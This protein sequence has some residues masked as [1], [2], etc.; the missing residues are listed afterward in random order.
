[1]SFA[2]LLDVSRS[3]TL[4]HTG[5]RFG[6]SW[7]SPLRSGDRVIVGSIA[8]PNRLGTVFTDNR[9][10]MQKEVDAAFRR[11]MEERS[12]PSPIWDAIAAAVVGLETQR[13]FRQ[14]VIAVTDG[15]S[16]GN[17]RGFNDMLMGATAAGVSVSIVYAPTGVDSDPLPQTGGGEVRILAEPGLL[18][19]V[20]ETGGL[21]RHAGDGPYAN[22]EPHVEKITRWLHEGYVLGFSAPVP[23]GKWHKLDVKVKR[24]GLVV[25]ARKAFVAQSSPPSR[26]P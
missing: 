23:D 19:L 16:T 15:Q 4:S 25:L 26:L 20:D 2:L 21:F 6:Q 8:R 3:M 7:S 9:R 13:Q 22:P 18:K 1:V 11:P 17:A 14:A 5:Y 24:P 12:G 10:E